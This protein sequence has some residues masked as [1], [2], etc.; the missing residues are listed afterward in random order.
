MSNTRYPHRSFHPSDEIRAARIGYNALLHLIAGSLVP[1]KQKYLLKT[2]LDEMNKNHLFD[3]P[4]FVLRGTV[5]GDLPDYP[6]AKEAQYYYLN[7]EVLEGPIRGD[8]P[9]YVLR[10][11][12]M[13]QKI[14]GFYGI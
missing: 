10:Y 3:K 4:G 14:N 11:E 5:R 13:D 2:V 7:S 12:E 9:D 1:K 6:T 8:L